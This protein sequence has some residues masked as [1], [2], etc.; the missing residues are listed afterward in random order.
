MEHG[1]LGSTGMLYGIT[2][3][4]DKEKNKDRKA[5]PSKTKKK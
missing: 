1:R 5:T 2:R 3:D 4:K